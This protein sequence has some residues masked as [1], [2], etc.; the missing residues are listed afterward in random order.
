MRIDTKSDHGFVIDA[1]AELP[2]GRDKDEFADYLRSIGND[3]GDFNPDIGER[4][5]FHIA[6][7]TPQED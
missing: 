5:A 1:W 6:V 4:G 7:F 2:E 3:V